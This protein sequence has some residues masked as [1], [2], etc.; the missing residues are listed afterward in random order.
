MG[1]L[2]FF[3]SKKRVLALAES[4]ARRKIRVRWF[5]LASV[6]DVD[7]LSDAELAAV[8]GSACYSLELGTEVGSDQALA[9]IGKR[10]ESSAALRV[11]R[12]LLE[13]GILP[14]HNILFGFVGETREDRRATIDVIRSLRALGSRVRFN[15]RFYQAA[16]NTTM[17]DVA[18]RSTP[19]LPSTLPGFLD[20]RQE[21]AGGRALPWLS[22]GDEREGRLLV[23]YCLPLAY[24][25]ALANGQSSRLRR[26]LARVS[27]W[28][29]RVTWFR[30]PLDR[31]VFQRLENVGLAGTFL[32]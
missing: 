9:K 4:F 19:P 23:D 21:M 31:Y 16:P 17:G 18:L 2:D 11:T 32:P 13:R 3:A 27:D 26:W 5:A 15:F 22:E 14:I 1:E 28:R 8:A 29:C 12:R 24:D 7:A 25:D 6:S 30:A 20:M 10:Y